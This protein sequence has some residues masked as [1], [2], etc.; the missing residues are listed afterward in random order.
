MIQ[1]IIAI[2][3]I[4]FGITLLLVIPALLSKRKPFEE[5]EYFYNK[6]KSV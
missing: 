4:L 6:M 2:A 1:A 3:A 5:T